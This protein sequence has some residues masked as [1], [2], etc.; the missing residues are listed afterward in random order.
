MLIGAGGELLVNAEDS[1]RRALFAKLQ[2][3]LMTVADLDGPWRKALAEASA[4]SVR[5][6]L[7]N[8]EPAPSSEA[9]DATVISLAERRAAK[10]PG[11]AS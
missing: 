2:Y 6:D 4:P 3:A 9:E 7:Q 5:E 10:T 8:P 1:E 11:T